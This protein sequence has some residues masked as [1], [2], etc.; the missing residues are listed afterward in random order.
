MGFFSKGKK[1]GAS[2]KEDRKI[3]AI[4]D[5]LSDVKTRLKDC[6]DSEEDIRDLEKSLRK[7]SLYNDDSIASAYTRKKKVNRDKILELIKEAVAEFGEISDPEAHVLRHKNFDRIN[8]LVTDLDCC[9]S[10]LLSKTFKEMYDEIWNFEKE[11]ARVDRELSRNNKNKAYYGGLIDKSASVN[12]IKRYSAEINK[13]NVNERS[14]LNRRR[15]L[16]DGRTRIEAKENMLAELR[17]RGFVNDHAPSAKELSD[18]A[19]KYN[20]ELNVAM[21]E[22]ELI[23]S[24]LADVA[25]TS[26]EYASSKTLDEAQMEAHR[27]ADANRDSNLDSAALGVEEE[28]LSI[29]EMK[30]RAKEG[31]L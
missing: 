15:S 14:L 22:N 12:E 10:Y 9:N 5:L 24:T 11:S 23:A 6:G 31:K 17:A 21:A 1:F 27:R 18:L 7:V 30:R 26:A 4:S 13:L 28:T 16:D 8:S 25:E 3:D 2:G 20:V 19:K 29:E